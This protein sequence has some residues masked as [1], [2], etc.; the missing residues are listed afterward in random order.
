MKRIRL[1][2][3]LH[4]VDVVDRDRAAAAEID[5]EDGEPDRR[6]ARG[7]GQHEHREHLPDQIVRG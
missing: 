5:D 7:D 4:P 2:Q 6:L 3:P 1:H